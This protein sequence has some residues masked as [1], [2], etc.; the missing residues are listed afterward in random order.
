MRKIKYSIVIPTFNRPHYLERALSAL[1]RECPLITP[2]QIIVVDDGS[3][4]PGNEKNRK[5]SER[6][7]VSLEILPVNC[8]MAVARNRGIEKSTG[9]WIIFLDDDVSVNPGWYNELDSSV[10]ELDTSAVG[11]EGRIVPS[12]SGVWDREV[13]NTSGGAYLTSHLGVRASILRKCGMFDP[14]FSQLGPYCEDHEF[15]ARLL[16]WGNVPFLKNLSVTHAPRSVALPVY[17]FRAPRRCY[18]L[19]S[20]DRYFYIRH[21]DRYH[22]FRAHRTFFGTL[23]SVMVRNVI[24]DLR[25]R[26][27]IILLRHPLQ[28]AILIT[29]SVIEQ[30][31]AWFFTLILLISKKTR[32][33]T[34]FLNEISTAGTSRL[35]SAD[36]FRH[37]YMKLRTNLFNRLTFTAL[38]RPVYD[39]RPVIHRL[40]K[41]STNGQPQLYLRIDDFFLSDANAALKCIEILRTMKFPFLAAVPL[42]DL[43]AP[44]FAP[45]VK[46]ISESEGEIALHGFTHRGNFGPF[47]S[48]MLQMTISDIIRKYEQLHTCKHLRNHLPRILVPPFNAIGPEQIVN[49][50]RTFPV[51]CGGPE[52][53]RFTDHLAGPVIL[54]NQSLYFPS[55]YPFYGSS[56][57]FIKNKTAGDLSRMN[58]IICITT[59]LA[60]EANDRFT[61]FKQFLESL[62]VSTRPWNRLY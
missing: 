60:E 35:W 6:F 48:E 3:A 39:I 22:C 1:R 62:P 55:L 47:P 40:A 43:I 29:G 25:R 54:K 24:N 21:P 34:A 15:A 42:R 38:R 58:G 52:T 23:R 46:H 45:F 4:A 14:V 20:C 16:Q 32:Y 50:S 28:S 61:S 11:F 37:D 13:S 12:G 7:T 59:H 33:T 19:L 36:K 57:Q 56:R 2:V 53:V 31:T 8:G 44:G 17:L 49:L 51:I 30:I 9:D 18:Q 10:A 41:Q 5:L 26:P 27:F